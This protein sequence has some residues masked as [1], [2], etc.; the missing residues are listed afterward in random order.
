MI[1]E[2]GLL[3]PDIVERVADLAGQRPAEFGLNPNRPLADTV[4]SVFLAARAHWRLF[5]DRLADA[6]DD[7]SITSLTRQQWVLPLLSLLDYQLVFQRPAPVVDG[8]TYAI[9]HRAGEAESAPPVHIVA[10]DQ[11]L[12]ERAAPGRGSIA[13][14]ALVQ[15]YLN[16]TEQLWGIATNGYTLRLLRDSS[17]FTR[18]T[19]VEFD[20]KQIFDGEQ[21]DE[22]IVFYRLVHRSRLPAGGDDTVGCLLERYHLQAVEQGDRIRNGLRSAV[23]EA[24]LAL[25]NG[26]LGHP[27]NQDLRE[28]IRGGKLTT[29]VLP[30]AA[31]YRLPLSIPDGGRGARPAGQRRGV[32]TL[33]QPL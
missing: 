15:D 13:P 32:D 4:A 12:G 18:P 29:R 10:C 16:R 7:E 25:A 30:A 27:R 2:G 22:F 26:L 19:Y 6:R 11:L 23:E 8:R 17:Y 20:L 9:S 33:P 31:V 5:Q 3:S 1:I 14:H 28:Q 21:L 24:I